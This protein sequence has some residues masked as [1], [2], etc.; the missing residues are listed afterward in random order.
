MRL[1]VIYLVLL[2]ACN[3]IS[4]VQCVV[5]CATPPSHP[6]C[7][8]RSPAKHCPAAQQLCEASVPSSEI[9]TSGCA[10]VAPVAMAAVAVIP[11]AEPVQA[12]QLPHPQSPA[13][14]A[15]PNG[16]IVLRI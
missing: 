14:D 5:Q 13:R 9:R 8:H 2:L 1:A 6:P 11:Y 15:L 7:H 3:A 4:D 16:T 12:I 10:G